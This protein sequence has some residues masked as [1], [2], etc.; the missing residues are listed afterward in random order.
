MVTDPQTFNIEQWRA[1]WLYAAWPQLAS[2]AWGEF[3]VRGRGALFVDLET[4]EALSRDKVAVDVAWT[5]EAD[6]LRKA[7]AWD[8]EPDFFGSLL[9]R[10]AAYDPEHEVVICLRLP[11]QIIQS[12][13]GLKPGPAEAFVSSAPARPDNIISIAQAV[14]NN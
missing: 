8:L 14:L 7:D 4:V 6:L 3:L 10:V 1:L 11:D 12:T 9:D 13:V 2:I 5:P